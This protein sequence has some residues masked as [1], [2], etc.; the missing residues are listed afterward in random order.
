MTISEYIFP[1]ILLLLMGTRIVCMNI[2][3]GHAQQATTCGVNAGRAERL[4]Q[5]VSRGRVQVP[6]PY[7]PK[8]R[9]SLHINGAQQP[10]S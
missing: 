9:T 2:I 4:V 6:V 10:G 8:I 7:A 5:G 3:H 1:S